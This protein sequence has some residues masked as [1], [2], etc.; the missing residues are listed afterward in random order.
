MWWQDSRGLPGFQGQELLRM[1]KNHGD[2]SVC[3]YFYCDAL[4]GTIKSSATFPGGLKRSSTGR[5]MNIYLRNL[6]TK[7]R[8]NTE[9]CSLRGFQQVPSHPSDFSCFLS[10]KAFTLYCLLGQPLTDIISLLPELG[11][12][13]ACTCHNRAEWVPSP[14]TACFKFGWGEEGVCYLVY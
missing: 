6:S 2:Q 10:L 7:Q 5:M 8:A 1:C 14:P 12:S 9:H 11:P 4:A 3:L 13:R